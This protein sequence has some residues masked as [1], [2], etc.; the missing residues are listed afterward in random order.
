MPEPESPIGYVI[1]GYEPEDESF[2]YRT[3]LD[4]LRATAPA[5]RAV[6]DRVF[7]RYFRRIMDGL[8]ARGA[9]VWIAAE[10]DSPVIFGYLVAEPD[11]KVDDKAG[12]IHWLYVKANWRR[13]GIA[14]EL[15]C[16]SGIDPNKA[17][18][19]TRTSYELSLPAKRRAAREGH[20]DWVH[21]REEKMRMAA[22]LERTGAAEGDTRC[23]IKKWPGATYNPF[24]LTERP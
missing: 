23:L 22:E 1:R 9:Q 17:Y 6:R 7:F 10:Q 14:T 5:Y 21:V 4:S 12:V 16:E 3:T 2:L 13:M 11:L 24:L 8:F 19:T 15:I 20:T 18:Y